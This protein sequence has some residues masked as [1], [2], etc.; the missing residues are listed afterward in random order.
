MKMVFIGA[1]GHA[2]Q[3][4]DALPRFPEIEVTAVAAVHPSEDM[5]GLADSIAAHRPRPRILP[6]WR[7][8][9]AEEM[10]DIAVVNPWYSM[11]ADVAAECLLSGC[12]VFTEKPVATDWKG[13]EK[14]LSAYRS[15]GRD[16]APMFDLLYAPWFLAMEQAVNAGLIGRVRLIHGQKSY[17]MGRRGEQY[18]KRALYG[19]M[20]PWVG[21]HMVGLAE[22]IAGPAQ[23]AAAFQSDGENRNHGELETAASLILRHGGGVITSIDCDYFRP[24][25]SA[26]H[27]DDRLRITGTRGMVEAIHGK[28]YLENE[29]SRRELSLPEEESPFDAF[30]TAIGTERAK[31]LAKEAFTATA[32]C[33]AAR[34]A[35]DLGRMLE[36]PEWNA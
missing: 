12:H 5:G 6:D 26:T 8:M 34:E 29:E 4:V 30:Y 9:L 19:G 15:T 28:V 33:L 17:K 11:N 1:S 25:G 7:Q 35:G 36:V 21:I 27:G 2:M 32:A 31:V 3:A 16:L 18:H 22:R 23:A 10:P 13:Y 24:D 14:L 20:I